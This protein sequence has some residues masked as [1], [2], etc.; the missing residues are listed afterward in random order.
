MS[1]TV[2]LVE[3]SPE[4]LREVRFTERFRGY[5]AAEVDA[6]LREAA[7]ALDELVAERS[8][9]LAALAAERARTAIDQVR[10]DTLAEIAELQSRRDG[11]AE[12]IRD[13]QRTLAERRRGLLEA[14]ELLDA[15][16]GPAGEDLAADDP[17]GAVPAVPPPDAGPGER[18]D[19]GAADGPEEGASDGAGDSSDDGPAPEDPG[20]TESFLARLERAASESARDTR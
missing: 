17:D 13:L 14:L 15:G 1:T 12:A 10:Q 3:L 16:G 20:Q 11:L 9:P 2:A 19:V 6:F 5:D 18:T 4:T 8:E 7:E